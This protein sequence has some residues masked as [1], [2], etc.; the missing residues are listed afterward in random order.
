MDLAPLP[1]E[2][3]EPAADVGQKRFV[4]AESLGACAYPR[5]ALTPAHMHRTKG[6]CANMPKNKSL[7]TVVGENVQAVM[8]AKKLSQ[9]KV[10]E[11]AAKA[12]T[13]IDQ[14]TVG[15][16]ANAVF[17]ATVDTLEAVANGLG[18][19]PWRL[20]VPSSYDDKF[21][22]ILKAWA[23]SSEVGRDLIRTAAMVAMEKYGNPAS[24]RDSGK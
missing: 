5:Q 8:L 19:E 3:L 18:V 4:H 24:Q 21:L 20:C 17:P 13:K 6:Y 1:A 9:P 2:I 12:G 10:A 15:R 23:V 7:R 14:T 22:A 11:A 16:V